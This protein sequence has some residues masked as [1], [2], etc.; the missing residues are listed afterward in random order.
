MRIHAARIV[1]AVTILSAWEA[2][3][4]WTF[5]GQ[6]FFPPPTA[7]AAAAVRMVRDGTLE[8]NLAATL[9]RLVAGFVAGAIPAVAVGAWL[10]VS[11]RARRILDPFLAAAHATPKIAIFPLLLLVFGLGGGP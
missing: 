1:I 4:R 11:R 7:V 5:A 8:R 6:L 10:G 2:A 3:G 9:G